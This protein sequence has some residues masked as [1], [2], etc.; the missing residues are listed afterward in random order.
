MAKA[1]K[2]RRQGE[3]MALPDAGPRMSAQLRSES[4]APARVAHARSAQAP[5]SP[6]EVAFDHWLKR[7]LGRLYDAALDE[8]V[9]E[10]LARLLEGAQAPRKTKG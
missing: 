1:A 4:A 8:P 7:E 9:P 3:P 10:E 6:G 2:Q 5:S